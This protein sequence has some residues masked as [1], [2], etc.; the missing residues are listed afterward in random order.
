MLER[1]I[2]ILGKIALHLHLQM[3]ELK[4]KRCIFFWSHSWLV[5]ELDQEVI[6]TFLSITSVFYYT[7]YYNILLYWIFDIRFKNFLKGLN[8]HP[9]FYHQ[10]LQKDH[11]EL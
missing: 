5:A 2:L 9:L 7:T 6:F 10:D 11:Q 1:K 4:A 3:S 8:L